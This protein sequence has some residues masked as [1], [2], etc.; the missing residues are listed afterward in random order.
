MSR[1][2]IERLAFSSFRHRYR[3]RTGSPVPR[4]PTKKQKRDKEKLND[5]PEKAEAVLNCRES[6]VISFY[7]AASR[8]RCT[9]VRI[10]VSQPPSPIRL[11]GAEI[12]L[13]PLVSK[14]SQ[15]TISISISQRWAIFSTYFDRTTVSR[16][17]SSSSVAI[18]VDGAWLFRSRDREV[19]V[20]PSDTEMS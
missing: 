19:S 11:S 12:S 7:P 4:A 9:V 1:P 8:A 13:E 6:L 10:N 2:S 5:R 16:G 3:D 15:A 17:A 18:G 14:R 20:L